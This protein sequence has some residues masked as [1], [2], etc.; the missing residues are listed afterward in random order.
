MRRAI[1]TGKSSSISRFSLYRL[2]FRDSDLSNPLIRCSAASSSSMNITRSPFPLVAA[3]P[4]SVSEAPWLP[5]A[6]ASQTVYPQSAPLRR[7]RRSDS[8]PG[9]HSWQRARLRASFRS[10]GSRSGFR[11][12][13][14]SRE[15]SPPVVPHDIREG[16]PQ[17]RDGAGDSFLCGRS[18][19]RRRRLSVRWSSG[20][21][22]CSGGLL[23]GT[24]WCYGGFLTRFWW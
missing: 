4:S 16:F 21:W 10:S 19:F 23:G 15:V 7:H 11:I 2:R 14:S 8:V 18:R 1:V 22:G 5:A 3:H 20:L 6:N 13:A 17:I 9:F 12:S 24:R